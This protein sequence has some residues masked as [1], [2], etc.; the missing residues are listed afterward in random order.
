ME[1]E[2]EN[3]MQLT[4]EMVE[5]DDLATIEQH[6]RELTEAALAAAS[7]RADCEAAIAKAREALE[8][9][10][11]GLPAAE[12]FAK[13]QRQAQNDAIRGR[14]DL[15]HRLAELVEN[16][17]LT[18][19]RRQQAEQRAQGFR[20]AAAFAT[21][22]H[23]EA[24]ASGDT[25]RI[26][27]ERMVE[28]RANREAATAETRAAEELGEETR[29]GRLRSEIETHVEAERALEAEI[30]NDRANAEARLK[31]LR[32][33]IEK[34]TFELH[35]AEV[36]L[37]RLDADHGRLAEE[38]AAIG[39]RLR[40]VG[41]RARTQI[42][43]RIED[44]RAQE[45]AIARQREE[46]E[47]LLAALE[48]NERSLNPQPEQAAEETVHASA[49]TEA[50]EQDTTLGTAANDEAPAEAPAPPH[51][52]HFSTM[53]YTAT[54]ARDAARSANP[55]EA[56]TPGNYDDRSGARSLRGNS[57]I[58]NIF[59]RRRPVEEP[60]VEEG[61]SIADRIA[62]DFGLLGS[63]EEEP[64]APVAHAV[65]ADEPAAEAEA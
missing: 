54:Q 31:A 38:R 32:E 49:V 11:T 42:E 20:A 65:P 36:N 44:L 33:T 45:A 9:A 43:A 1:T 27:R 22:G 52:P 17:D 7:E 58:G 18:R 30:A 16:E 51:Q 56:E 53:S 50:H 46:Q 40:E 19:Q 12:R 63:I 25:E 5:Q 59:A 26:S 55:P 13:E 47:R 60:V 37:E 24:E 61:P 57:L 39:E 29:L 64:E 6:V 23:A 4:S 3:P 10:Q 34:A 28:E 62:R 41:M 35:E 8:A 21:A 2:V 48:E 14:A 15:E